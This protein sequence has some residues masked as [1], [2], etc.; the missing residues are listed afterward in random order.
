MRELESPQKVTQDV[1]IHAPYKQEYKFIGRIPIHK[2]V[3]LY[4]LSTATWELTPVISKK[5]IMVSKHGKPVT[6]SKAMYDPNA[7]YILAINRANAER[8]AARIIKQYLANQV[9]RAFN[10]ESHAENQTT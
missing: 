6:T 5:E 9:S 3:K 4:A 10:T 8:K 2:G 7:V 1:A